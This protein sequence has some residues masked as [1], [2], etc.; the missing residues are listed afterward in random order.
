MGASDT[1]NPLDVPR[2]ILGIEGASADAT[3][4]FQKVGGKH[5]LHPAA[6]I[7]GSGTAIPLWLSDY[8]Y[9]PPAI[10]PIQMDGFATLAAGTTTGTSFIGLAP[11]RDL[12]VFIN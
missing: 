12:E 6:A 3:S 8:G 11:F 7:G 2:L 4:Q 5:H 9:I 10:K 1:A